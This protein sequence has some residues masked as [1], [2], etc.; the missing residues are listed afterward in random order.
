MS[1]PHNKTSNT[2]HI[3]IRPQAQTFRVTDPQCHPNSILLHFHLWGYLKPPTCYQSQ[4]KKDI[5]PTHFRLLSNHSRRPRDLWKVATVRV[6]LC[7][8]SDERYFEYF[9]SNCGL[10]QQ[11]ASTV[12]KLRN[13]T[14]NVPSRC[15]QNITCIRYL[16]FNLIVGFNS[17]PLTSRCM[18]MWIFWMWKLILDVCP[19]ILHTACI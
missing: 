7:T 14:V 15:K 8:D 2:V 18:F 1:P 9:I 17:K 5:L 19:S 3:H 13:C 12:I 6:H 16:L 11:K 10:I 4:L